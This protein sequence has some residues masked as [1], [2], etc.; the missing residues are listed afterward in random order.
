MILYTYNPISDG[1]TYNTYKGA[2]GVRC[3]EWL[4]EHGGDAAPDPAP[5]AI[6]DGVPQRTEG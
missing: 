2:H 6:A 4:A 3:R 1:D 5:T